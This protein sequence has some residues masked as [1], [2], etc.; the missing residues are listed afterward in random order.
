MIHLAPR[1]TP[2]CVL[3]LPEPDLPMEVEEVSEII[4]IPEPPVGYCDF[5]FTEDDYWIE[6]IIDDEDMPEVIQWKEPDINAFISVDQEAVPVNLD[7]IR[8]QVGYPQIA[9]D[10]GIQGQVVIRVLID[11]NG[12][13]VSMV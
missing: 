1:D 4:E 11:E 6:E 8:K 9:R 5:Q 13:Y 7:Q 3:Y 2:A 12:N 10:A